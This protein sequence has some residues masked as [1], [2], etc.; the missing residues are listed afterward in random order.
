M[1]EI[2]RA[3]GAPPASTLGTADNPTRRRAPCAWWHTPLPAHGPPAG[4]VLLFTEQG[5][6]TRVSGRTSPRVDATDLAGRFGG[7][8]HP[9]AAGATLGEHPAAARKLV[10]AEARPPL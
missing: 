5:P 1:D 3:F 8:G 6:R 7:G 2:K 10:L 9:R 4:I